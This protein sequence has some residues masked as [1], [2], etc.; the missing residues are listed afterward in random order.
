MRFALAAFLAMLA[1]FLPTASTPTE[2]SALRG[3]EIGDIDV[4]TAP[5]T[6]FFEFANGKWRAENPIP[7]SMSRWS[8]RWAAGETA[9][10]KLRD[11]LEAASRAKGAKGSDV[12]LIGDFYAGCIDEAQA[13]QAGVKPVEPLLKEIDALRDLNDVQRMISKLHR[14]AIAVP[15]QLYGDSDVHEPSR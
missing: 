5:C 15:F 3:V 4:K 10:D 1:A 14:I 13:E 7:P 2:S 8:R 9:K 11:I 6:D 12:Q